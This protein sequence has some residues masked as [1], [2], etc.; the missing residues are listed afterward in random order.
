MEHYRCYQ[1]YITKI[2]SERDSDCVEFFPNNIP[3]PYNSSSDN[4]IITAHKLDHALHNPT[5][6]APFSNIGNY[7]MVEIAQL[8]GIFSKVAANLHQTLEPPQQHPVTKSATVSH[9]MCPIFAKPIPSE[10]PILIEDN[11]G[12]SPTDFH[13]IVH[14]SPSGPHIIIPY[15]PVPTPRVR[16]AQPPR[17][18][19]G[20]P[21]SNLRSSC[22][23]NPVP[24]FALAEQC[25]KVR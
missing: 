4:V 25:L 24:N 18:D 19:T 13:H 16:P 14:M 3:L 17:V 21:S 1:I 11:D 6:Q 7:Q 2:R 12:N 22:N 10:R 23:K 20:G 9:N 15:D 5:P 8:S